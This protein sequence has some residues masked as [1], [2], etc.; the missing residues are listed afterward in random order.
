ML[1]WL[2]HCCMVSIGHSNVLITYDWL[3]CK[4]TVALMTTVWASWWHP[5]LC[6]QYTWLNSPLY[7][8]IKALSDNVLCETS[9]R[10]TGDGQCSVW[11][12]EQYQAKSL[13][14][15]SPFLSHSE[16]RPDARGWNH[17]TTTNLS[18]HIPF[19]INIHTFIHKSILITY[20]THI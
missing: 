3:H 19:S 2:S 6:S 11:S 17:V 10:R 13:G 18:F 1:L 16:Q 5:A 12:V 7:L 14:A 8:T 15:A 9:Q 20:C 4:W